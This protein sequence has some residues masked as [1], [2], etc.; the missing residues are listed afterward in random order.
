MP[1]S[2]KSGYAPVGM[3]ILLRRQGFGET[4]STP[5]RIVI[6]TGAKRSGGACGFFPGVLSPQQEG[7]LS[8]EGAGLL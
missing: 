1:R 5:Q 2:R 7:N 8:P 3:T 4:E 6:P